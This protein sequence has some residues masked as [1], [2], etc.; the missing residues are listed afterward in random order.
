M[1]KNIENYV[2][3]LDKQSL[4]SEWLNSENFDQRPVAS[5]GER[6]MRGCVVQWVRMRCGVCEGKVSGSQ[7]GVGGVT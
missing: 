1:I 7:P 3:Y 2:S 6:I 4:V 5:S